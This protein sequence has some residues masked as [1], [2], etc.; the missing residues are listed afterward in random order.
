MV[1]APVHIGVGQ[2]LRAV[3][4]DESISEGTIEINAGGTLQLAEETALEIEGL[5]SDGFLSTSDPQ[6]TGAFVI[7]VVDVD[8]TDFTQIAIPSTGGVLGDYSGNDIVD[9]VQIPR[10]APSLGGVESLIEQPYIMSYYECTADERQSFGIPDNMIRVSCGI[11]NSEDLLADFA[12]A[13]D[14]SSF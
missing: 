1:V 8:G 4:F 9:A 5:I 13:F 11:E 12:Q 10:I 14:S 3:N 6:G 2:V 7:E